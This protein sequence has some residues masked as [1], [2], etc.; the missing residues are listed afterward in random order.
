MKD[1]I[2]K[3]NDLL[4][5]NGDISVNNAILQNIDLILNTHKGEWKEYVNIGAGINQWLGSNDLDFMIISQVRDELSKDGITN[6]DIFL[7]KKGVEVVVK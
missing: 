1:L 2:L 3:D 6:V 4:F 5:E 7:T